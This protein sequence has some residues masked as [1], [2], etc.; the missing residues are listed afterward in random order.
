MLF[1]PPPGYNTEAINGQ[2]TQRFNIPGLQGS[3]AQ[4]YSDPFKSSFATPSSYNVPSSIDT[5]KQWYGQ[6]QSSNPT[7]A[8]IQALRGQ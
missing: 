3:L 6:Q 7:G 8:M 1:A 5:P 2:N 4:G